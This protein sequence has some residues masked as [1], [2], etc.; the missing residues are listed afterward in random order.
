M[1]SK[2]TQMRARS[3]FA[4][5][6]LA[7]AATA[8]AGLLDTITFGDTASEQSHGLAQTRSEVI[9]GGLGE[10]AR[11]LLPLDP[12]S[13]NGGSVSF[14]LKVEP[15]QQN[16]F[17]VKLWGSDKGEERGRLILYLNG[18]QVGYR[19]EGDYDVL[20]QCDTEAI[21]PGRF[22]YQTLPLPTMLTRGKTN[23]LLKIEG[24]GR[25]WPYGANFAE[26]QKNLTEPTRGLYRA[27]THTSPHFTPDASEK[28]GTAVEPKTRPAGPGEEILEKMKTTVNT[29][30]TGL[31]DD[32]G[33][34]AGDSKNAEANVLLLAEA[35]NT[36]WTVAYHNPRAIAALVK[37][38]DVF[39]RPGVIG[40]N[41][42]GAGPLGEAI[43]RVGIEPLRSAL[44]EEIELPANFPFVPD[45]R[46]K[47]ALEEPAINEKAASARTTRMTRRAAWA[48]VLRAS[49]DW[50]RKNGRRAYTN[51]SMI[52]DRNLYTANR[53][54]GLLAPAEALPEEQVLR[55]LHESV[56][57]APW[58][59]NDTEA[60]GSM[61]PYGTNYHQITLKGLS[62][63]LGYVGTYG[64]TILKF[65]RDMVE[66]TGDEKIRRQLIR[67][68]TARMNFR[69]PGL[70]RDGCRQMKLA[71]EIDN[72]TAHFP[73]AHGA[74]TMPNIREAWWMELPALLKDPV[75]VGA[76]QQCLAD[77]QYFPRLAERANDG[78]TLGMMR[79]ID[80]YAVVKALPKSSYRLPMADGQP[81]FVYSDEENAVL[82]L[83]HGDQR[84]FV[85]FY[86]R[87]EYGVSGATRILDLTPDIL[88]IATVKSHFE[89]D[90]TGQE[91][92][93]PDVIDFERS[94]GFPPPGEKIHQAWRGEKLPI[95]RRP[96]DATQ[97]KYGSWGPFVGK[98][99]FYWLRYGDY[100]LAVNTTA[101]KTFDL[102]T[103]ANLDAAKDLIA[104][105]TLKLTG[106]IKVPPHSTVALWLGE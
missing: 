71:G 103:P 98:A 54:L 86:F 11:Q 66:L 42:I 88:R 43:L 96:V 25:M 40:R 23:V 28:Q 31:M 8:N 92:T 33:S 2:T 48:K 102:K 47:E 36:P 85:N 18:E 39:L 104:G 97:P 44:D 19:H 87:Q 22:L 16:Y 35:Y 5:A 13:F 12:V 74:Y 29:R 81:D 46:R 101:D 76:A 34:R 55:Y 83:K 49:L 6:L 27:C 79:N 60:G 61:K 59:G 14:H 68:E 82:A 78:D 26:K 73:L 20:N 89:V 69:Y 100:L 94:G 106:E 58:L 95:A 37:A 32:K 4:A 7:C 105:K 38:G 93:R 21:F 72:R 63:E 15:D 75:S 80:E 90:S 51:Q 30:L 57:L 67:I 9:R 53:G 56:G 50:N 70:D 3:A 65:M 91:W 10:P 64:E 77:N 45:W 62:R 41:W 17:T 1:Q 24:L 52:V 99:S 84:L